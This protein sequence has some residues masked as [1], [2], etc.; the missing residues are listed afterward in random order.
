MKTFERQR[1]IKNVTQRHKMNK[2]FGEKMVPRD[3]L[4]S[5]LPEINLD[6]KKK[7]KPGT[8]EAK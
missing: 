4:N 6:Q 2:C 7:K 8:C 1:T 5:G 3:L